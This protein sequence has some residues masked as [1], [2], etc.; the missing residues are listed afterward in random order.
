MQQTSDTNETVFYIV[1][2]LNLLL[3]RDGKNTFSVFLA[4]E[5]NKEK[6]SNLKPKHL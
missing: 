2:D 6:S 1:E 4:F 3:E 5:Y